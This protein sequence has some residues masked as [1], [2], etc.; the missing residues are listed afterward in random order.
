MIDARVPA[1]KEFAEEYI[2]YVR[3][4]VK[5]HSWSRDVFSLTHLKELFEDLRRLRN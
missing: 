3:D 4:V 2:K 1:L 5:K